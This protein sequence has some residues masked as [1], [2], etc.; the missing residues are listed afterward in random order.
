MDFVLGIGEWNCDDMY[1]ARANKVSVA[2]GGQIDEQCCIA[3]EHGWCP[4]LDQRYSVM[5]WHSVYVESSQE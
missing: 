5:L 1:M 3:T 4:V 2:D